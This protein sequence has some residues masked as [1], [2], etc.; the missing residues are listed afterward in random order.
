MREAQG[1][2]THNSVN[3]HR[4]C[5][6][7]VRACR[8]TPR[9]RSQEPEEGEPSDAS[10]GSCACLRVVPRAS[11][12]VCVSRV[13]SYALP[14]SGVSEP[15][16]GGDTGDAPRGGQTSEATSIAAATQQR[17]HKQE[18]RKRG[19][20]SGRGESRSCVRA[21]FASVS[22][23]GSIHRRR[24]ERGAERRATGAGGSRKAERQGQ[25]PASIQ[26]HRG[27]R[28]ATDSI[29]GRRCIVLPSPSCSALC[30]SA[31]A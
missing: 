24:G 19:V 27:D 6:D 11:R 31:D 29:A 7:P 3:E 10:A 1:K 14:P 12:V 2:Q 5:G 21:G 23:A 9:V 22:D 18:Q 8:Q 26:L 20:S 28:D 17:T 30:L 4:R 13:F 15:H 16:S 25:Q